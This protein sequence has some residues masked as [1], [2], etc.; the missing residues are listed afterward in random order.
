MGRP[1][2]IPWRRVCSFNSSFY[3][4]WLLDRKVHMVKCFDGRWWFHTS[5]FTHSFLPQRS[6]DCLDKNILFRGHL[7]MHSGQAVL[8]SFQVT[9]LPVKNPHAAAQRPFARNAA[10]GGFFYEG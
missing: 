4:A 8:L 1:V 3:S 10:H 6:V 9:R 5:G 2:D 7:L